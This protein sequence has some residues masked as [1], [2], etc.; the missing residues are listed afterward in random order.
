MFVAS[1]RTLLAPCFSFLKMKRN[2]E[3][4]RLTDDMKRKIEYNR[5][6]AV[7][8]KRKRNAI[9]CGSIEGFRHMSSS[10]FLHSYFIGILRCAYLI[11]Q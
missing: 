1:A 5:Q 9:E 10:V 4:V 3:P 8:K 2:S 6:M 11:K 7:A